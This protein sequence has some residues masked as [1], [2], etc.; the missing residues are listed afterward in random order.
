M[1]ACE[2]VGN[3]VLL[4]PDLLYGFLV[5]RWLSYSVRVISGDMLCIRTDIYWQLS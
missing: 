2:G 4:L 1:F 5:L 3:Y